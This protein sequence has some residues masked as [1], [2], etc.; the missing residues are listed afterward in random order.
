[1]KRVHKRL[2]CPT[3]VMLDAVQN[4]IYVKDHKG[5]TYYTNKVI[6]E[7]IPSLLKGFKDVW[8]LDTDLGM[9]RLKDFGIK[10]W[11]KDPQ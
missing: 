8:C 4:G 2:D 10:W 6:L 11:I 1:M 3:D 9:Y 5:I 7:V